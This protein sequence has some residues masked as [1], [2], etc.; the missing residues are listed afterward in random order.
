MYFMFKPKLNEIINVG[1]FLDHEKLCKAFN[2]LTLKAIIVKLLVLK[3][4]V[5]IIFIN[6]LIMPISDFTFP[7]NNKSSDNYR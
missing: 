3:H 7:S 1:Y 6:L 5:I 2:F 4:I